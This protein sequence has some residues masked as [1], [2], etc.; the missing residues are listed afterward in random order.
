MGPMAS[1][2]GGVYLCLRLLLGAASE[3][4]RTAYDLMPLKP[5]QPSR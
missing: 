4:E 5:I 1:F 2:D 3:S